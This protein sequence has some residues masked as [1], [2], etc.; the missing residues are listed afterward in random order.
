MATGTAVMLALVCLTIYLVDDVCLA[1][2]LTTRPLVHLISCHLYL[3]FWH[4][5]LAFVSWIYSSVEYG[6][7]L[8]PLA[9]TKLALFFYIIVSSL[10]FLEAGCM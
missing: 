2:P 6:D 9:D 3:I 4:I 8:R 10:F 1:A 7:D 5:C